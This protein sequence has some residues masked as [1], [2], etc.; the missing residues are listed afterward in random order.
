MGDIR[1]STSESKKRVN[2][3]ALSEL[4]I[5][6]TCYRAVLACKDTLSETLHRCGRRFLLT[7][8]FVSSIVRLGTASIPC[9]SRISTTTYR[10]GKGTSRPQTFNVQ[11]SGLLDCPSGCHGCNKPISNRQEVSS[12]DSSRSF[13]PQAIPRRRKARRCSFCKVRPDYQRCD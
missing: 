8:L 12:P 7:R 2:S 13:I 11:L 1:G 6:R 9:R 5:L 3:T 4:G 10:I